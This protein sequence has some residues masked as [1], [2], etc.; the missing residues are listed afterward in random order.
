[1]AVLRNTVVSVCGL[2]TSLTSLV[3]TLSILLD[4]YQEQDLSRKAHIQH[5]RSEGRTELSSVVVK[6]LLK[7]LPHCMYKFSARGSIL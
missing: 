4:L 5:G 3:Y 7:I 2:W 1:M 6:H